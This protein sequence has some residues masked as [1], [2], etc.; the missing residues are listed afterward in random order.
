M[1]HATDAVAGPD[2]SRDPAVPHHDQRRLPGAV[3][4][5]DGRL[6]LGRNVHSLLA[7][8]AEVAD[9]EGR[10]F[11]RLGR[12]DRCEDPGAGLGLE[13][14]DRRQGQLAPTGLGDEHL[15]QR[16]LARLLGGG[17]QPQHVERPE[18]RTISGR[19]ARAFPR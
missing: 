13:F 7:D 10:E 5:L 3:E 16:M 8:Q 18:A 12:S 6:D 4:L 9:E 17:G 11:L 15:R 2:Q 19:P 1:R 14:V